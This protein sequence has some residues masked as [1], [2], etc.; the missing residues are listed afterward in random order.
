MPVMFAADAIAG[1]VVYALHIRFAWN[2]RAACAATVFDI[3]L[4]WARGWATPS[5][6]DKDISMEHRRFLWRLMVAV[7]WLDWSFLILLW[8]L[9]L[10][11]VRLKALLPSTPDDISTCFSVLCTCLLFDRSPSIPPSLRLVRSFPPPQ[12]FCRDLSA[13]VMVCLQQD[14][15]MGMIATWSHGIEVYLWWPL[16]CS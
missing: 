7:S 8:S 14:S 11:L 15:E 9:L 5:T 4:R 13:F 1:T 16:L 3:R 2:V 10:L 12:L 6:Y